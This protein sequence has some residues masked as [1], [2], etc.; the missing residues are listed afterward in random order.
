MSSTDPGDLLGACW[1]ALSKR[2]CVAAFRAR[3]PLR[4]SVSKTN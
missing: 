3:E 2:L 1:D 4:P